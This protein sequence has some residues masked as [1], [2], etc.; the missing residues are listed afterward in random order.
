MNIIIKTKNLELTEQLESFINRKIGGLKKFFSAFENHSLPIAEGRDLF[1]TFVEVE[2]VSQHHQKGD[3]FQV[4]VKL[5]LPGKSLFAKAH[6]SDVI[7]IINEV[8]DK[9]EGEIRKYKSKV[10][11]FPIRKSKKFNQSNN[12]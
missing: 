4:E 10:I 2:K 9:L 1:E 12:F 6:G 11:E 8:R 7:K 5:Y 3:V